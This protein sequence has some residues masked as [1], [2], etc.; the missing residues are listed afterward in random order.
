MRARG[1]GKIDFFLAVGTREFSFF[2]FFKDTLPTKI[3]KFGMKKK[4]TFS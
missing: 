3:F 1:F 2:L 4:L